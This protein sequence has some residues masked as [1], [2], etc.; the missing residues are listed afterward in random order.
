V[1]LFGKRLV[2]DGVY[3]EQRGDEARMFRFELR[4]QIAGQWSTQL[5]MSDGKYLWIG[6]PAA[7]GEVLGRVDLDRVHEAIEQQRASGELPPDLGQ[8]IALGGLSRLLRGLND[9]FDLAKAEE[10]VLGERLPVYRLQGNWK[11]ERLA[12]LAPPPAKPRKGKVQGPPEQLPSR[13]VLFLE[14]SNLFPRRVEFL[15]GVDEEQ[16]SLVTLELYEVLL[17]GP[18]DRNNFAPPTPKIADQTDRYLQRLGLKQK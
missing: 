12:K 4:F 1:D 14:K 17:N 7:N 10:A 18:L 9:S 15:R 16:H 2:G 11:P 5:Q 8:L 13:V 6:D 3:Q